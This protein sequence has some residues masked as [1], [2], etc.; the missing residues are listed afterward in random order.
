MDSESKQS[1]A[2]I[3]KYK[4]H[5]NFINPQFVNKRLNNLNKLKSENAQ[6][7]EELTEISLDQ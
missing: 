2:K 4:L 3:E 6:G 1:S 5:N 7:L